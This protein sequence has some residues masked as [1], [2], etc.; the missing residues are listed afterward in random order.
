MSKRMLLVRCAIAA[1]LAVLWPGSVRADVDNTAQVIQD[2]QQK[3]TELSQKMQE[4]DQQIQELRDKVQSLEHPVQLAPSGVARQEA[5]DAALAD[6]DRSQG[7]RTSASTDSLAQFPMGGGSTLKLI[8]LSLDVLFNAGASTESGSELQTLQ[9]GGHDPSQRGF[10]L[11]QA[12]ISLMGAVDPYLTGEAH[13]VY[14]VDPDTGETLS[15]LEE[16]FATTTSLPAGLQVKAGHFLSKFG[17]INPVHPHAWDWVDQPVINSRIFGGDGMRQGGVQ[18]SWLTPLP[19][20]SELFF[21]V[22]NATGEQ[23]PS[24]LAADETIAGRPFQDR[25]VGSLGD[26]VYTGRWANE[27]ELSDELSLALGTSGAFGANDTGGDTWLYGGDMK[28]KWKPVNNDHGWPFV[29]WQSEFIGRQFEAARATH[30][31]PDG[32]PGGGDDVMLA[33]ENLDDWGFYT[34]LLY[35]FHRD[36]A[37]GLRYEYASGSG[38]S[39]DEAGMLIS[40]NDDPFRDQ[41]T[42]I[43]PLLVWQPTH[44]SRMR[45][46]YNYDQA[47][48]LDGDAQ[49]LWFSLEFLFGAHPAH[50]Y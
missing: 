18:V 49:S 40:H 4:K 9:G 47:E 14:Q 24:F 32:E 7:Q 19:W 41:R 15:E 35:G 34:Q 5:I 23:M 11:S 44:F 17:L 12:E 39:V 38:N 48:H 8:D 29:V 22:Q 30:N 10:T 3:Y 16:A 26:L 36:W 6:I 2:L 1:L 25:K 21:S 43:S 50:S 33:S 46:Q 42:R 27:W 31:G 37:A 13:I 20:Y 45:L 28:L